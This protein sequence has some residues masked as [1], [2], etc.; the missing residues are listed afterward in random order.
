MEW[1]NFKES[2]RE[3]PEEIISKAVEGFS[4][5]TSNLLDIHIKQVDFI[6]EIHM[7]FEFTVLLVSNTIKSYRFEIFRFG[8]NV[9]IFPVQSILEES[10]FE[11]LTTKKMKYKEKIIHKDEANF[12]EI[13]ELIFKSNRFNE[14]VSGLMKISRKNL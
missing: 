12:K 3:Y 14:I 9:D 8:Y 7:D 2:N 5:A 13:I 4:K 10:I 11:E 6:N 1:N